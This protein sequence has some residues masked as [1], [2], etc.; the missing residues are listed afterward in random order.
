MRRTINILEVGTLIVLV[1][2]YERQ[3]TSSD[4]VLDES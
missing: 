4:Q 3:D 2:A 1:K